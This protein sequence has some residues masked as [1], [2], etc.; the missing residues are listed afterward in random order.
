MIDRMNFASQPW[1]LA[2][3]SGASAWTSRPPLST[4]LLSLDHMAADALAQRGIVCSVEPIASTVLATLDQAHHLLANEARLMERVDQCVHE[5]TVL[6][7]PGDEYDVSHSEPQWRRRIFISVPEPSRVS[8]LRVAEAI[9]HEAMH[10]N[11]T[12]LEQTKPLF[13]GEGEAYSPW[14]ECLRPVSGV[15][16]GFYVFTCI[17]RFF[18]RH[19]LPTEHNEPRCHF[20]RQR[21]EQIS[22]DLAAVESRQLYPY[23]TSAGA[24]LYESLRQTC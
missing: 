17:S 24:D 3:G 5:V 13:R 19:L 6:T 20:I 18:E 16:H 12:N 1:L 7:A 14:R 21:L 22:S 9:V 2:T 4:K 8:D 15:F 10:L 11:L 23:L